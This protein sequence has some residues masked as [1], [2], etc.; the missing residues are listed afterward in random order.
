[1]QKRQCRRSATHWLMRFLPHDL[2][3]LHFMH[4]CS[5]AA[6]VLFVPPA[7]RAPELLSALYEADNTGCGGL[8][9]QELVKKLATVVAPE[10]V[11]DELRKINYVSAPARPEPELG[12]P[13]WRLT[14][15]LPPF[16]A[17]EAEDCEA[18]NRAG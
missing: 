16:A 5:D 11:E 7:S 4:L 6:S 2:E 14:V 9:N 17:P 15:P 18:A 10:D 1:M 12:A 3:R 13:R 8:Q